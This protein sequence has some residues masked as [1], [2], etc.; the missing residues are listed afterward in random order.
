MAAVPSHVPTRPS[1]PSTPRRWLLP[2]EHGAYGQLA[3]PLLC[4]LALGH[5]RSA[6]LAFIV[7]SV[8]LFVAHEPL[9]V[10]RGE[11][12][13]KRLDAEGERARSQLVSWLLL[14][15]ASGVYALAASPSAVRS[16]CVVPVALSLVGAVFLARG[17]EKTTA[18]EVVVALALGS[19]A[20][21]VA[22][23]AGVSVRAASLLAIAWGAVSSLHVLVVR[24][25]LARS[26]SG[27]SRRLATVVTGGSLVAFLGV[28]A[29][30]AMRSW[31]TTVLVAFAPAV[32]VACVFF[33]WPPPMKKLRTVGWTLMASSLATW[34]VLA[35]GLR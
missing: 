20:L 18:G 5:V 22:M 29:L 2:R 4:A 15:V 10:L 34:V 8:A 6:A 19:L 9:L 33:R 32:A 7:A 31:P 11:R 28:L 23:A 24:G 21:P 17:E 3:F 13:R 1:A 12:G 26:R 35:V 14:G 16:A 27:G 30:V 25:L